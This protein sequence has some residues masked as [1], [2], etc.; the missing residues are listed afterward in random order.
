MEPNPLVNELHAL[1]KFFHTSV[2]IFTEGDSGFAPKPEMFTVAQQV[3]HAAQTI[4]WFM[5]AAFDKEGKGF[6]MDFEKATAETLKVAS[7][8]A[9]LAWFDRACDRA[10]GL[11]GPAPMDFF[12][13]P[14]PNDQICP[15]VPRIWIIGAMTDHTAHHRG[16][17]T[18]Y[19]RLLGK[20]APMPYM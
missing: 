7:L 15:G 16:A 1:R 4:D 6:D 5:D 17:L 8:I 11:V 18:V 14:I 12:H 19:A 9:A 13:Q 10:V 20:V 2:S 3:A